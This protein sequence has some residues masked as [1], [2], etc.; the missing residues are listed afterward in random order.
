MIE[1]AIIIL[2]QMLNDDGSMINVLKRRL[3]KALKLNDNNSLFVVLGGRANKK[4][5]FS[6]AQV[7]SNYLLSKNISEDYIIEEDKSLDTIGNVFFLKRDILSKRKIN[8]LIIVTSSFHM[9][10]TRIIF[11]KILGPKYRLLFVS[12][13]DFFDFYVIKHQILGI[14]KKLTT[15]IYDM[16]SGI[17]EGDD[18]QINKMLKNHPF[19][20]K[21]GFDGDI[22]TI[23]NEEL[24]KLFGVRVVNIKPLRKYL[25][26]RISQ[27]K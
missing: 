23:S 12:S 19:Y 18:T 10:R 1:K 2:G 4:S 14:E 25:E 13:H 3:D 20:S 27:T 22:K 7:M 16:L 21:K 26:K 9:P 17:D 6:E 5:P 15:I 11:R 24:S 8:E